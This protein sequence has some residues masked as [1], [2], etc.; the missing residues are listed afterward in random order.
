MA[1]EAGLEFLLPIARWLG[2]GGQT[3]RQGTSFETLSWAS[4]LLAATKDIVAFSTV[5]VPLVNPIFAA[6]SMVTADHVGRGRCG[7]N[8]VS[9]WNIE[10]FG[11]FGVPLREHDER[12]DYPAEWATIVKRVWSETEPFDF[13]AQIFLPEERR[14]QAEAVGRPAAADER[15]I[16]AAGRK[17]AVENADCLFMVIGEEKNL[18]DEVSQVRALDK[19]KRSESTPAAISF[20]AQLRA[21]PRTTITTSCTRPETG[22]RPKM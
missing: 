12:Y 6:K 19:R 15:R 9:G 16:V 22:K 2:Y 21:K 20:A 5:H 14:R 11:M 1:D 4:A 13:E 17:F 18:A 10:E 8:I 7:L 3:D